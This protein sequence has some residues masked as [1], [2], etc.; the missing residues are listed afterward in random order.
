MRAQPGRVA[1]AGGEGPHARH[2][3]TALA[4]DRPDF[5]AG[6]PGQ[7]RARIVAED[8]VRD[9][10]VEIGRR[11]GAATGLAEA[12]GGRAVGTRNGLDD[13]EEGEGIGLDPVR[14]A[15]Q[16]QAEQPRLVQFVEQRRG[17]P[18]R[19]LDF[20][21]GGRDR[22]ADRLGTQDHVP[23]TGKVGGCRN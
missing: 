15:W 12:P 5:G 10:Q 4:F 3:V 18:A 13:V 20:P 23:V 2:P 11:H 7:H 17:Q 6:T 19:A 9:R 14:R 22:G 21:G 16:Q 8:R 1:T